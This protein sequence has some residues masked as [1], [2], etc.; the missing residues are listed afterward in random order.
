MLASRCGRTD[1]RPSVSN[2]VNV[3]VPGSPMNCSMSARGV[4]GLSDRDDQARSGG[5]ESVS[6]SAVARCA[7]LSGLC[8]I[9]N[10]TAGCEG[11][12]SIRP[13]ITSRDKPL[14][15]LA[16]SGRKLSRQELEGAD[17][18]GGVALLERTEHRQREVVRRVGRGHRE[19]LPVA[20]AR[21]RTDGRG[22]VAH[23]NERRARRG[24]A[25]LDDRPRSRI[26]HVADERDA[27]LGDAD[28]V[29]RD[30]G[31]SSRPGCR[32]GRARRW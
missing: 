12:N 26:G 9:S 17:R 27:G 16:R 31:R 14:S 28:F 8:A 5:P 2:E 19:R 29:G 23:R 20:L 13:G 24:A 32:C 18:R 7:A 30:L 6:R 21:P 25:G 15:M 1:E 4:F 11:K 22:R 10:T 3:K